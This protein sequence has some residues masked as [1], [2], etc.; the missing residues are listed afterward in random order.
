[1]C[2]YYDQIAAII[3]QA[4]MWNYDDAKCSFTNCL[5]ILAD[6]DGLFLC[7]ITH[8]VTLHYYNLDDF[9]VL[10][11]SLFCDGKEIHSIFTT[12]WQMLSSYWSREAMDWNYE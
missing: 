7:M 4:F 12:Y 10:S 8:A 5:M 2:F 1:M 11:Y 3:S 9:K 6:V